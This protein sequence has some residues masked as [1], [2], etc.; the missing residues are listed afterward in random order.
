VTSKRKLRQ[1]VEQKIVAGWDDPRLPTLCGMRKRGYPAEAIKQFCE[2]IGISRSDSVIDM[3]LLEDCVR[4]ELNN[5]AKRA[6]C[7]LEPLKIV[8]ENYP[9]DKVETL[10]ASYHPHDL[11]AGIR[12][13]P[14]SREIYIE[15][16]DFMEDPPKK[17]FRL[18]PGTEVRLRH[19]YV[20]RCTE[21]I[22]DAQDQ[23]IELRCTYDEATL[24]K[25]PEDRKIK[26]VIHWVSCQQAHPVTVYQYDR[27]FNDANPAREEDFLQFLNHDSLLVQQGFCEPSLTLQPLGEVFQFERLGY[28][29]VNQLEDRQTSAFHRVVSLKDSWG[30]TS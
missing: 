24:G 4:T 16:S 12:S 17:Y 6:M 29:A 30:K 27:L 7:V 26:G 13:L 23:V 10:E 15:R 18:S 2:L 3:S 21:V 1:L 9:K 28:Y 5:T 25:N 19:A 22:R 14:F 11:A 8:I 20:I